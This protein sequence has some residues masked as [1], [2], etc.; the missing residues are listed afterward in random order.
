MRMLTLSAVALSAFT[1]SAFAQCGSAC[2]GSKSTANVVAASNNHAGPDIVDTAVAA[3]NFKTLAAALKAADLVDALKGDGP[4]TVFAPTDE[5][6]A[7]LPAGTVE[8]LLKP[9]NK[10]LLQSILLYHVAS[11][12]VT[13]SQVTKLNDVTTLNGQR[14]VIGTDSG[15]TIGDA[16]V[17]ATDI[18]TSNGVIHVIDQVI[19]PETKTIPEVADSAQQFATL[20]AA[21]EAAGLSETLMGE[22]PFTVF[23]PTDEAFA[24]LPSGTV[25]SLLQPENRAKLQ[26]ILT[27]HVVSGRVFSDAAVKLDSAKT[28]A[29]KEIN[30]AF[31]NG[32]LFINR[33][34]VVATDI[35]A[36][37]GVIHV[38]DAV[39]LP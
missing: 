36:S 25:E 32:S 17:V 9:E 21:V 20:L 10:K 28:V 30:I 24:A 4:F 23:A 22:G 16:T 26:E 2:S 27:Y 7:K 33:S 38:I 5:A 19:L 39:L 12:E 6:F 29:G 34:E 37:N 1:A 15:V 13:A 14:A 8:T 18:M 35:Q 31:R 3:G 11:G